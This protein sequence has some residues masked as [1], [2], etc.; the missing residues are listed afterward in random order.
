MSTFEIVICFMFFAI[1]YTFVL[2]IFLYLSYNI[3]RKS[4][5]EDI[6]HLCDA[7]TEGTEPPKK[8]KRLPRV[9]T[10]T[11]M[12]SLPLLD[13]VTPVGEPKGTEG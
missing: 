13:P 12:G 4:R 7:L 2:A 3:G 10:S 9:R 5:S 11:L 1:L 6:E 8:S